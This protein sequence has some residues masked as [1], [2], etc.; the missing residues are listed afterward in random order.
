MIQRLLSEIFVFWHT[1]RTLVL[2]FIKLKHKR[3]ARWQ[4]GQRQYETFTKFLILYVPVWRLDLPGRLIDCEGTL[5]GKVAKVVA[6]FVAQDPHEPGSFR[7][8][9][10]VAI[11]CLPRS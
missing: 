6:N 7:T 2:N 1:S 5:L 3:C 8:P 9:F 11:A 4:F 10:F